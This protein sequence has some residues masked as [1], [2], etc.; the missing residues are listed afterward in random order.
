MFKQKA[1]QTWQPMFFAVA[2]SSMLLALSSPTYAQEINSS[3]PTEHKIFLP[4]VQYQAD[5][6]VDDAGVFQVF[7]L[8]PDLQTLTPTG[9][10]AAGVCIRGPLGPG[11][12][13]WKMSNPGQNGYK[14]SVKPETSVN[15]IWAK[16][17]SQAID[18]V[19]RASWGNCSALKVPDSCTVDVNTSNTI[20]SCCNAAMAA[21][22]HVVKWTNTCSSSSSESGWP[23][24]PLR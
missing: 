19:Y 22:G 6:Q 18:G 10:Q 9:A 20:S 21:L 5:E 24:N 12:V 23:D 13:N 8:N 4:V 16:A 3:S 17:P 11:W 1:F 14:Y 7:E 2:L 15:L